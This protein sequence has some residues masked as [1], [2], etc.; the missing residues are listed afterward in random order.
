MSL[1]GLDFSKEVIYVH[2]YSQICKDFMNETQL[3]CNKIMGTFTDKTNPS[4][5]KVTLD[6]RTGCNAYGTKFNNHEFSTWSHSRHQGSIDGREDETN[7]T[8]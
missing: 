6:T 4:T 2:I 5:V 1:I 3:K 7:Q 8:K